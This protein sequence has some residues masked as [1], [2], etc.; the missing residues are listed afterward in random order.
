M[1]LT[2][3]WMTKVALLRLLSCC[4][5]A[6][7]NCYAIVATDTAVSHIGHEERRRQ[8]HKVTMSQFEASKQDEEMAHNETALPLYE[9]SCSMDETGFAHLNSSHSSVQ[10]NNAPYKLSLTPT[11]MPEGYTALVTDVCCGKGK[12]NWNHSGNMQYRALIKACTPLYVSATHKGK[13]AIILDILR[14]VRQSGGH[15]IE[16]DEENCWYDIGDYLAREKIAHSL[17]DMVNISLKREKRKQLQKAQ[18]EQEEATTND[19]SMD[20]AV[21]GYVQV[22]GSS[23]GSRDSDRYSV[24]ALQN[25][26]RALGERCQASAPDTHSQLPDYYTAKIQQLDVTN[27]NII[28]NG[29]SA[30]GITGN[31]THYRLGGSDS[32]AQEGVRAE[33]GVG[34]QLVRNNIPVDQQA[35]LHQYILLQQ[36]QKQQL[37]L[38]L[39]QSTFQ[40]QLGTRAQPHPLSLSPNLVQPAVSPLLR[41]E[42]AQLRVEETSVEHKQGSQQSRQVVDAIEVHRRTAQQLSQLVHTDANEMINHRHQHQRRQ[43]KSPPQQQQQQQQC[44]HDGSTRHSTALV[45]DTIATPLSKVGFA[46]PKVGNTNE[47]MQRLLEDNHQRSHNQPTNLGDG[48]G[49]TPGSRLKHQQ[50]NVAFACGH[51]DALA[52]HGHTNTIDTSK[53]KSLGLTPNVAGGEHM[54]KDEGRQGT[55]GSVSSYATIPASSYAEDLAMWYSRPP[56]NNASASAK[57]GRQSVNKGYARAS[58]KVVDEDDEDDDGRKLVSESSQGSYEDDGNDEH[59]LSRKSSSTMSADV[60]KMIDNTYAFVQKG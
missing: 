16:L 48:D 23:V 13:S 44:F 8:S 39:Q 51:V 19:G 12:S 5:F 20:V 4:S 49:Y 55:Q 45:A 58:V 18:H 30:V 1:N 17:R 40:S 42:H 25:A 26:A 47:H 28:N 9:T 37:L 52:V 57:S 14:Q 10:G 43:L 32:V 56:N 24:T 29:V 33:S 60:C 2:V 7:T 35:L 41:R 3:P 50:S 11:R 59:V 31:G 27:N 54:R 53:Q 34:P 38:L 15:F 21:S 6:L 46:V 36:R 22:D